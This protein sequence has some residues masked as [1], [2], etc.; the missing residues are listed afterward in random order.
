[1]KGNLSRTE[2][3]KYLGKKEIEEIAFVMKKT[4]EDMKAAKALAKK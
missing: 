3:G 1:M 2:L 4:G